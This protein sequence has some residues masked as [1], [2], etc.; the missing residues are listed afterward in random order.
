MMVCLKDHILGVQHM[1]D[2]IRQFGLTIRPTKTYIAAKEVTFLDYTLKQGKIMP[3]PSLVDKIMSIQIPKTKKQI[4]SLLSLIN[5]YS[6][7]VPK[8]ADIVACLTE[9]TAGTA[10]NN[11]IKWSTRQDQ[12][13]REIQRT[14]SSKHFHQIPDLS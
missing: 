11:H 5:F 7:F 6:A 8:Y 12:A 10:A 3:G 9:L 2:R 14:L 4:R 13:L 1:L